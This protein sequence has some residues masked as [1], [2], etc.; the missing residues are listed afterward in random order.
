MFLNST[1]TAIILDSYDSSQ[2]SSIADDLEFSYYNPLLIL[3]QLDLL[4]CLS[5]ISIY[6]HDQAIMSKTIPDFKLSGKFSKGNATRWLK[7][8]KADFKREGI[9]LTPSN[10][11][12]A[13]YIQLDRE[14]V[15]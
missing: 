14:A 13:I 11:L 6:N 7:A 3:Q 15:D 5:R 8:I 9:D 1:S 10:F 4:N 12:D 2:A